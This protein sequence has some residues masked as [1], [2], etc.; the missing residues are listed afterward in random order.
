MLAPPVKRFNTIFSPLLCGALGG[1]LAFA[2][3]H[4]TAAP[5]KQPE[6][7][8]SAEDEPPPEDPNIERAREAYR[9][10]TELYN[11]AKF[12]EALQAFQEAATLYAS[13]DF[14]FNIAKCYERLG[15]YEEA[16]RSY[17]TYL[18][19]AEDDS[20]HAVV[21]ASI[22]DLKRRIAE[23]D[24]A[25]QKDPEPDPDPQPDDKPKHPG[26][27]LIITGGVLLGA[28][29]VF[30]VAGGLANGLPVSNKNKQLG[31][32]LD[33]NPDGLTFGE[34][35]TLANDARKLQT[36]EIVNIAIGSA[37]AV[38]GAALLGVGMAK[39]KKAGKTTA[40]F[41]VAPS[42]GRSSVGLTLSG[43]F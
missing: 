43:R 30:A 19:T 41:Q 23:R 27:A 26:R 28:G 8:P 39:K 17:E 29:V 5:P 13:P 15:K 4:V 16:I 21:Q 37:I 35:N 34:A 14:Q 24:A 11:A 38:T 25:A 40:Q 22:E 1:V 36:L 42:W 18:R 2:P 9:Q 31:E 6:P 3:V 32:V 7:E 33:T 20:D 10:G 12:E